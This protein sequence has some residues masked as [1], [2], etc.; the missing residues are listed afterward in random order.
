MK[1]F[2]AMIILIVLV[3]PLEAQWLDRRTAGIPRTADGKPNLKAAAPRTADGKPD[4]AGLWEWVPIPPLAMFRSANP[5][6]SS[7]PTFSLGRKLC[8]N[9]ALK[10]LA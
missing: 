7:L 9:S 8:S 4:L 10:T 5:V 3:T 1:M 6:T 2:T